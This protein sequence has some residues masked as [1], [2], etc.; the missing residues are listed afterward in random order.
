MK[1]SR[2]KWDNFIKCPLCFYLQEKYKIKPP[3][4]PGYPINSRVDALLKE[5][6][7]DFRAKKKPHPIFKEYNLNF[8]PYDL[9]KEILD[10][11]RNN[12]QGVRAISLKTKIELYGALDDLWFN[13]DTEEIVVVDYK[14]TSNKKL[15]DYTSSKKYYH[16]AYLRQ[17]DFYSYLLKL[18]GFKVHDTGYW[19]ICN[20]ANEK[21]NNF[22]KRI[23]FKTTLLSYKLSSD[24]IE[25][26]LVELK[27]CLDSE[28]SPT[29]G[30][31]CDNCR[32]YNEKKNIKEI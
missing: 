17:L 13:K 31:N 7:D 1:L 2:S 25:D 28:N 16:K 27:E 9:K 5:E 14:A 18:N 21:Q 3:S 20:G 32:W 11:Y 6:F 8:V 10:K 4:T 26:T 12:R 15:E 19:L 24:Y 23:V 30:E 29:S 22:D